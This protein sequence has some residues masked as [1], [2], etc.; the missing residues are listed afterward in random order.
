MVRF[1][2]FGFALFLVGC[3]TQPTVT[4]TA[5]V[6]QQCAPDLAPNLQTASTLATGLNLSNYRFEAANPAVIQPQAQV[7]QRALD[8]DGDGQPDQV[9]LNPNAGMG[10]SILTVEWGDGRPSGA[11]GQTWLQANMVPSLRTRNGVGPEAEVEAGS[12][13]VAAKDLDNNGRPELLVPQWVSLEGQRY[14]A[15]FQVYEFENDCFKDKTELLFPNQRVNRELNAERAPAQVQSIDFADVDND[16][17]FDVVLQTAV[18]TEAWYRRGARQGFPYLFLNKGGR[19]LPLVA[20]ELIPW[21]GRPGPRAGDFNG[22]GRVDLAFATDAGAEVALYEQS[23]FALDYDYGADPQ[24]GTYR[25]LW[26]AE[27]LASPGLWARL[28]QDALVL[29]EGNGNFLGYGVFPPV[30]EL[31]QALT[32]RYLP[33]GMIRAEGV[34]RVFNRGDQGLTVLE[35]NLNQAELSGQ[36]PSGDRVRVFLERTR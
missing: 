7:T 29:R 24:A 36:L 25:A 6:P 11:F 19:Y 17:A 23:P 8:L 31:R 28:G 14:G 15:G 4:V 34:L 20:D 2:G 5:P 1:G 30:K 18:G 21:I 26:F 33:N 3:Q 35:G 10:E 9:T 16:G 12:L 32:V 13:F 27:N 22:D